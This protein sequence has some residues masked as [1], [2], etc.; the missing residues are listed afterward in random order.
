MVYIF[1][2]V[3][4]LLTNYGFFAVLLP[5]LLI[6][7]IVYG[8]LLKTKILGEQ[9]NII[10]IVSLALAFFVVASTNI[11]VALQN[12]IPTA[13]YLIVA[14]LLLLIIMGFF[15][16]DVG[17]GLFGTSN[18]AKAAIL[19]LI[20]IIFLGVIDVTSSIQI[21]II[22]QLAT[23]FLGT[24]AGP[25]MPGLPEFSINEETLTS[26]VALLIMFGVI[27]GTIIFIRKD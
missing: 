24:G 13:S 16:K 27:L 2:N 7:A 22:H 15:F 23:F 19:F 26:A 1:E 25:G 20:L 18:L 3:M 8:L 17:E 14:A 4:Q 10:A 6:F 12:L 11:V 21:P 9:K 5:W